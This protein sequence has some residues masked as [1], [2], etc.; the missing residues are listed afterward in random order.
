MYII[1]LLKV[2]FS[3]IVGAFSLGQAIPSFEY[4]A[5]ALGAA[6]KI[7]DTIKRVSDTNKQT[8]KQTNVRTIY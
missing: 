2:F 4:F 7:V 3:I 5:T 8:N 1:S 6:G